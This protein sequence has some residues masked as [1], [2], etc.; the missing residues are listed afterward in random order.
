[1]SVR[2]KTTSRLT[3]LVVWV[4][5]GAY[6]WTTLRHG[7]VPHDDGAL[8]QSA[9]RV[10]A[11]EMPHRD[12]D[13]IYT[14]ALTYLNA[15][16]FQVF[17]AKLISLRYPLLAGYVAWIPV[18]YWVA[19]RFASPLIAGGVTL[20][21][22]AWSIPIYPAAVPSWYILFLS[23][24]MAAAL[25]KHAESGRAAWLVVAGLC[26]GT[27]V[28]F[29]TTG[30]YAVGAGAFYTLYQEQVVA[31]AVPTTGRGSRVYTAGLCA[32]VAVFLA[33]VVTLVARRLGGSEVVHFIT[34]SVSVAGMLLAQE[35]NL[36][37]PNS[38]ERLRRLLSLLSPFLVGC[39]IAIA[40]FI[41]VY[42]AAGALGDLWT[43]ML[44]SLRRLVYAGS[45]PPPVWTTVLALLAG[46]YIGLLKRE[47]APMY[48]SV[49]MYGVAM[50][51]L[52]LILSNRSTAYL[53]L[54]F[55]GANAIPLLLVSAALGMGMRQSRTRTAVSRL[56]IQV[57]LT[58]LAFWSLNQYPFSAPVYF[59]YAAPLLALAL[60]SV[61]GEWPVASKPYLGALLG[62]AAAFAFFRAQPGFIYALG[63]EPATDAYVV[64]LGLGQGGI[65]VTA[66]QHETYSR[67]VGLLRQHAA[68]GTIWAGPDAPEVYFLSGFPNSTRSVFDFLSAE[69]PEAQLRKLLADGRVRAVVINNSPD[70]S[71]PLTGAV[72][73]ELA[74]RFPRDS[75]VERF[76]VRWAQ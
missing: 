54:W 65:R 22:T 24:G 6:G 35:R 43:G 71:P 53:I 63:R 60:L 1:M 58:V 19:R 33:A 42:A 72:R 10:L 16:A 38:G 20:L 39:L 21:S 34:P 50:A 51:A 59:A 5:A 29:K 37:A 57:V 67:L 74:A 8:A 30:L 31:T 4:V 7:W 14:G 45:R 73:Q 69:S 61:L 12:F 68:G 62:M 9:S 36:L 49:A 55:T 25:L 46:I 52:L 44:S 48:R 64:N 70:F 75:S 3:F 17:G 41:T 18:V 56:R 66:V 2:A 23:T 26:A 32:F 13:E 40:P 11:G 28:L 47:R 15:A 76:T 27:A